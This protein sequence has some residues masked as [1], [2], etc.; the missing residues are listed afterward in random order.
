MK[1]Q[2]P[3]ITDYNKCSWTRFNINSQ[4]EAKVIMV[5][6]GIS[7]LYICISLMSVVLIIMISSQMPSIEIITRPN[8]SVIP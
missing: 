2:I 5:R 7:T 8:G 3:Q 4:I 1:T 6:I